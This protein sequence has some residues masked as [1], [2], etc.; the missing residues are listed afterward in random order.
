MILGF[1]VMIVGFGLLMFANAREFART[2]EHGVEV[3]S[4]Y[5]N[6]AFAGV[7]N[8]FLKLFGAMIIMMGLVLLISG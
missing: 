6:K 1:I 2:N 8:G 7:E 4:D 5:T 3:Y